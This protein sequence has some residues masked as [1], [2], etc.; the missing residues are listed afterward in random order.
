MSKETERLELYPGKNVIV[1]YRDTS[2]QACMGFT[3]VGDLINILS[4]YPQSTNV[5]IAPVDKK[6]P[7]VGVGKAESSTVD[8]AFSPETTLFG[9]FIVIDPGHSELK[10]GARGQNGVQEEDLNRLQADVV[11]SRLR[12]RM[13]TAEVV[14]PLVDDLVQIGK[15]ANA[16]DM[17][18]SLHHNACNGKQH[19]VC[20][21][22]HKRLSTEV[23]RQFASLCAQSISKRLNIPLYQEKDSLPGVMLANLAVLNSAENSQPSGPC[24][25]VE[26]YFV[27][28]LD[29]VK[30]AAA[31][32]T[33]AGHAIADTIEEWFKGLGSKK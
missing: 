26:S 4:K 6:P 22:V 27:D 28:A 29:D 16:A 11:A 8:I 18:L 19:Y 14:D 13:A 25:L 17:F 10:V 31:M 30:K 20:V 32:T 33:E 21:L 5:E 15:R 1:S 9:R 3:C 24:V 2:P 7:D 23:S 12:Y